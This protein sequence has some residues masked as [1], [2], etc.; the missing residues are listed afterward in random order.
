[1]VA[2]VVGWWWTEGCCWTVD[3]GFEA[4]GVIRRH[5]DLYRDLC[6]RLASNQPQ[7]L[8]RHVPPPQQPRSSLAQRHRWHFFLRIL[9]NHHCYHSMAIMVMVTTM[10]INPV[11]L[12]EGFYHFLSLLSMVLRSGCRRVVVD[13]ARPKQQQWIA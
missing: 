5:L 10:R 6:L 9:L 11:I 3:G 8:H 13:L 2:R 4:T 7:I 12:F 1:M